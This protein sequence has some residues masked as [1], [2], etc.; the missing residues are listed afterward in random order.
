MNARPASEAVIL[1]VLRTFPPDK[2]MIVGL[3]E[4]LKISPRA[5][6]SAVANL[7]RDGKVK[8]GAAGLY[9]PSGTI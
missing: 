4:T 5:A 2:P 1:S 3:A 6:G 8:R 7:I 9:L